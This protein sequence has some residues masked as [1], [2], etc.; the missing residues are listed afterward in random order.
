M[1][2]AYA[3]AGADSK[4]PMDRA[5]QGS[6]TSL[7]VFDLL[8]ACGVPIDAAARQDTSAQCVA[9][10]QLGNVAIVIDKLLK[11]LGVRIR[12]LLLLHHPKRAQT[13]SHLKFKEHELSTK[14]QY[15]T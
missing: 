6:S 8:L 3:Y 12:I 2:C 7:H 11:P 4:I 1:S 15:Q 5:V 14:F 10:I 9:A 13:K